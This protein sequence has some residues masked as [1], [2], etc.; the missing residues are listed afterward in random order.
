MMN[1]NDM[2]ALRTAFLNAK[3]AYEEA[4]DNAIVAIPDLLAREGEMTAAEI[5]A[6][7][8]LSIQQVAFAGSGGGYVDLAKRQAARRIKATT[9]TIKSKFILVEED[10]RPV[11]GG[12]TLT[13]SRRINAYS[14]K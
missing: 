12:R 8:G 10:G 13:L 7:T 5:S 14:V 4:R 1:R 6:M 11:E 2:T 9:R 3:A